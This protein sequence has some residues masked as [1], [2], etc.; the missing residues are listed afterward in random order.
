MAP[1]PDPPRS[2]SAPVHPALREVLRKIAD[3][4]EI[5]EEKAALA[6][7]HQPVLSAE[8][9]VADLSVSW[10][11]ERAFLLGETTRDPLCAGASS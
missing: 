8:D 2:R 6:R 4:E 5:T 3:C 7:A 10:E 11:D 1:P 9:F